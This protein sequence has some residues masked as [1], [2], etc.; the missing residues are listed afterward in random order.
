M[1]GQEVSW[2][3][4][5]DRREVVGLTARAVMGRNAN[6]IANNQS[7]YLACPHISGIWGTGVFTGSCI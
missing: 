4:W 6:T 7:D 1:T 3:G 5:R 2:G